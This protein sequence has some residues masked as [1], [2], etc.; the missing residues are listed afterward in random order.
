MEKHLAISNQT[1]KEGP[2]LKFREQVLPF[3]SKPFI[4]SRYVVLG[5]CLNSL[6]LTNTGQVAILKSQ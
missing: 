2:V 5:I 1:K 6:A 4:E 3:L